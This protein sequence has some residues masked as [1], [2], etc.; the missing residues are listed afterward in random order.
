[1]GGIGDRL[2]STVSPHLSLVIPAYNEAVRLPGTLSRV[3]GYLSRQDYDWEVIVVDDGSDDETA[4]IAGQFIRKNKGLLIINEHLGKACAVRSGVLSA[5]GKYVAFTDADLST[6]IQSLE[7]LLD[8]LY[9]H[10]DVA[11]GSREVAGARRYGEPMTRHLIGRVF[12]MVQQVVA[13]PGISDTQCGFKGFRASAAR[14]V[15]SRL[16]LYGPNTKRARGAMVTAFDVELLFIARKVGLRICEI[17]VEWHYATGSKVNP[18]RDS[19]RML[20]DTLQVRLNDAHG[21]YKT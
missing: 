8:C 3:F 20:R 12:N 13:I 1:M 14:E 9:S 10:C 2:A 19:I 16:S 21:L 5:K 18:L 11:I 7:R 4:A 6:P 15:F 17:P